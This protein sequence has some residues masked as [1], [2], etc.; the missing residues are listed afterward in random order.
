MSCRPLSMLPTYVVTLRVPVL[1]GPGRKRVAAWAA[2]VVVS[3]LAVL[4]AG[5]QSIRFERDV[6][7]A[8]ARA[9]RERR[10]LMFYVVDRSRDRGT[11]RRRNNAAVF[12][13]ADVVRAAAPFIAVELPIDRHPDLLAR[14]NLRPRHELFLVFTDPEGDMLGKSNVGNSQRLRRD[15]REALGAFGDREWINVLQPVLTD[16]HATVK[17]IASALKRIR[18]MRIRRA[19]YDVAA[20]LGRFGSDEPL[21][22]EILETL[23]ALS[24]RIATRRLI[25]LAE[26]DPAA[27]EA[28]RRCTPDAAVLMAEWLGSGSRKLDAALYAAI[29]SIAAMPNPKSASFWL[30]SD[31]NAR[32][33][34][35]HR[36]RQAARQAMMRAAEQASG[37]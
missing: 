1:R 16:E 33:A 9:K 19:D 14:W 29:A 36:A 25:T 10:P 31:D 13:D 11:E 21:H 20:L 24:T 34:E 28:L 37:G 27:A 7:A 15:I 18:R 22:R 17:Q 8:V 4:N 12:R 32:L 30:S 2:A 5:A 3:V 6:N 35:I 23:A 26:R